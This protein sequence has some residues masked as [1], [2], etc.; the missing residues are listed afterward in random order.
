MQLKIGKNE[1][2][3]YGNIEKTKGPQAKTIADKLEA[4]GF[5]VMPVSYDDSRYQ[6]YI[7]QY[8]GPIGSQCLVEIYNDHCAYATKFNFQVIKDPYSNNVPRAVFDGWRVTAMSWLNNL[9]FKESF[10]VD[11]RDWFVR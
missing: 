7:S 1:I 5:N 4:I 8:C 9:D 6:A 10:F 3:F 11:Y 2:E